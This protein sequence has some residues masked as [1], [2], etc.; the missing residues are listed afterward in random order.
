[1]QARALNLSASL[2]PPPSAATIKWA[3]TL[4]AVIV[5]LIETPLPAPRHHGSGDDGSDDD[6]ACGDPKLRRAVDAVQEQRKR[7]G[8]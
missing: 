4:R 6:D 1:M 2:E 8:R 5:Q 3:K 7:A